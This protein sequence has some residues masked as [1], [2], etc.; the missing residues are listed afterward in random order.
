MTY[1]NL[2]AE[3]RGSVAHITINRPE[4]RNSIDLATAKELAEV[5]LSLR[6]DSSVRAVIITGQGGTFSVGGD[7]KA[8]ATD[9]DLP[10]YLEKLTTYLHA[11]ISHFVRMSAPVITA[12]NGM[13]AGAGM[14]LACI[15]DLTL[16]AESAKFIVAYSKIGLTPDGSCSYFLPRIIGLKKALELAL[17]NRMLSAQEA[18]DW[19][20]VTRVVPDAE[21][22]SEAEVV[23]AELASGATRALG[24]A[25]Q[26][27][28]DGWT[29]ALEVQMQHETTAISDTSRT[30]DARE[31]ITAFVEKRNPSFSGS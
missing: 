2:L 24:V 13:A 25:K 18:L 19:G 10:L 1:A 14:S 3:V 12:V 11:A 8:F 7:V 27:L 22:L 17:T 23:A 26:L 9:P 16:A 21:L 6:E 30:A 20:I 4:A 31:G 29:T 5:A 15:G 28:H